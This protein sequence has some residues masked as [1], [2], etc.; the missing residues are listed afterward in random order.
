MARQG[1]LV[2]VLTL[3]DASLSDLKEGS[4]HQQ[5]LGQPSSNVTTSY[6]NNLTRDLLE[7]QK[8]NAALAEE[9]Q[10]LRRRLEMQSGTHAL[11]SSASGPGA[12]SAGAGA[13]RSNPFQRGRDNSNSNFADAR[14]KTL[15]ECIEA[16]NQKVDE[17]AEILR[18]KQMDGM[19]TLAHVDVQASLDRCTSQLQRFREGELVAKEQRN[20]MYDNAER[21][22][23]RLAAAMLE[24]QHLQGERRGMEERLEAFEL[25]NMRLTNDLQRERERRSG[26]S[27][28]VNVHLEELSR[29]TAKL[30]AYE[31]E[32]E[33]LRSQNYRLVNEVDEARNMRNG[34]L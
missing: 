13:L 22:R 25:E 18:S 1:D 9:N 20:N 7:E 34:G 24:I 5:S 23:D 3:I 27:D 28:E 19:C 32:N 31:K 11:L 29:A 15:S 16:I 8:Q 33:S 4:K 21:D 30:Q 12:V 14:T 26:A 10:I 17:Q 6:L 2:K